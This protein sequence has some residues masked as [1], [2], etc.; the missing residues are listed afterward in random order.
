MNYS[1]SIFLFSDAVKCI[2][3]V[4]EPETP[5]GPKVKRTTFKTFDPTIKVGDLVAV[6]SD[7]RHEVTIC[8]VVAIDVEPDLESSQ[9]MD[10]VIAVVPQDAYKELLA[11]EAKVIERVQIAE[12][13]R[14]RDELRKSL[15]ADDTANM[16]IKALPIIVQHEEPAPAPAPP[17]RS[18]YDD[19]GND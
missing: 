18:P 14:K 10:W 8:K 11:E 7:T 3:A 9:K 4:Y 5:N 16:D 6:P 12:R 2:H 17:P 1:T 19:G 15:M 13:R